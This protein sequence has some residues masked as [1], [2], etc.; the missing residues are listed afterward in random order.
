[1]IWKDNLF[2]IIKVRTPWG[3]VTMVIDKYVG[4]V[5]SRVFFKSV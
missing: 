2:I 5:K 1:L 4:V 3:L